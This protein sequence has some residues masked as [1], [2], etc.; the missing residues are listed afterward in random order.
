MVVKGDLVTKEQA[1]EIIIRTSSFRSMF[2]NDREFLKGLHKAI[3][4]YGVEDVYESL[5]V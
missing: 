5:F 3:F 1:M 2:S 4:G